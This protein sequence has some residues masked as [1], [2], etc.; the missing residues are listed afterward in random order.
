MSTKDVSLTPEQLAYDLDDMATLL[1]LSKS[2]LYHAITK[3]GKTSGTLVVAGVAI[4][5]H[6]QGTRWI[7]WRSDLQAM[8]PAAEPMKQQPRVK[9]RSVPAPMSGFKFIK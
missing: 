6:K 3:T 1:P 8:Q 2:Q 4:P 9:G 7:V 5:V